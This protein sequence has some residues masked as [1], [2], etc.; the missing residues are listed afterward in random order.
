MR[1]ASYRFNVANV[2]KIATV[3]RA[4]CPKRPWTSVDGRRQAGG[5]LA[6]SRAMCRPNSRYRFDLVERWRGLGSEH[7]SEEKLEHR[8][9]HHRPFAGI[10]KQ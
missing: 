4:H 2:P 3:A 8:R 6:P 7:E 10:Y 5:V 9:I 1:S